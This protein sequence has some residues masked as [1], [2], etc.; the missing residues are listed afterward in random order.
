MERL[1]VAIETYSPTSRRVLALLKEYSAFPAP[2][3]VEQCTR[4]KM[5]PANLR[6]EDLAILAPLLVKAIARFVSAEKA[7]MFQRDLL[8]Q[9]PLR[10]PSEPA[11][12]PRALKTLPSFEPTE[13]LDALGRA[14]FE[15]LREVTPLA[16]TLLSNQCAKRNLE[17]STLTRE[18]WRSLVPEIVSSIARFTSP[19]RGEEV[20][21]KMMLLL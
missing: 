8:L 5:D 1:K 20:H 21:H 6:P 18:Q 2:V 9:K 15:I 19:Q 7:Q 13:S 14:V 16:W 12:P 11:P 17:A 10:V 3:L 4:G